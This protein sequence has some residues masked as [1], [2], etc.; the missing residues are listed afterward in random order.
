MADV[1]HCKPAT[2]LVVEDDRDS[3]Q[4]LC[5]ILE[6]LG[7]GALSFT[8]P[9]EA[10]KTLEDQAPPLQVA[11]VDVMMPKMN[12]FELLAAIKKLPAYQS[13]PIILVTA[14]DQDDDV[15]SGYER[16]AD[17]YIMKPYTASQ[18]ESGIRLF[19]KP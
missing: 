4:A 16:G 15:F 3:N 9:T 17:Y 14:R 1:S 6:R 2:V 7:L 19:L 11:L 12:G 5:M 10:L 13:M 8:S 18:L